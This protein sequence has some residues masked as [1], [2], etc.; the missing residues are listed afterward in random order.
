MNNAEYLCRDCDDRLV[1]IVGPDCNDY[2]ACME[3][4]NFLG[5][6]GYQVIRIRAMI[7]VG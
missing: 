7:T 3:F 1:Y 4:A 2:D 5:R 6:N